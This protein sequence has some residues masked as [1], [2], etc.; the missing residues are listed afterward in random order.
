MELTDP[1]SQGLRRRVRWFM[2]GSRHLSRGRY[3]V[4][5]SVLGILLVLNAALAYAGISLHAS[6]DA[7]IVRTETVLSDM[8]SILTTLDDAETD[9][10]SYILTTHSS[11]L[12]GFAAAQSTI[13]QRLTLL[14]GAVSG[15]TAQQNSYATLSALIDRRLDELRASV[16]QVRA[17]QPQ[18]VREA[19]LNATS[20]QT[21]GQI[22]DV[23][24]TMRQ[25]EAARL[26][27]QV[28]D[29]QTS[30]RQIEL[31][32]LV[33]T[34]LG[35]LLLA[36]LA[37]L[38]LRGLKQREEL[39]E[40][41]AEALRA[42]THARADAEDAVRL[43]DQFLS[44]A[45][46]E[47]KNPLTIVLASAQLLQRRA[48]TNPAIGEQNLQ[49]VDAIVNQTLRLNEWIDVMLDASRIS[50]GNLAMSLAPVDALAVVRRA[51]AETVLS[52]G[53]HEIVLH[54]T[55]EPLIVD[56]DELRLEQVI[57]NLVQNA[58]KYSPD[59]GQIVVSAERAP[60]EA[61]IAVTDQGVGIPAEAME[62]LFERFYR[63]DNARAS[64]INGMGVGLYLVH[65]I[66]TRMGG[67]IEVKSEEGA[68]STFTIRLPLVRAR[69]GVR[70][71]QTQHSRHGV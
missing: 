10:R 31:T 20:T 59:G 38:V 67:H 69:T 23:I 36:T 40:M 7:R 4:I 47:L 54:A 1:V 41:R 70:L 65:E 56:G 14:D 11:D 42:E 13:H 2:Q 27:Q 39:A 30:L 58:I 35:L 21:V 29:S 37:W 24:R 71:D 44:I 52:D 61:V 53:E 22:R 50:S 66:V 33:A 26:G 34:A 28:S 25:R 16:A 6:R 62:H 19:L 15:D 64:H 46:H 49:A 57:Q 48:S 32:F 63:A 5:F 45:S 3:A 9:A 12:T 17:G 55:S 18:Q 60:R 43:R 51:V 68:G 8:E